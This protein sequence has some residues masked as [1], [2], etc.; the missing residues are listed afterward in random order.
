VGVDFVLQNL[1][2][3][4]DAER[5]GEAPRALQESYPQAALDLTY[6]CT[7]KDPPLMGGETDT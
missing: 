6:I 1:F 5:R 7:E 4:G 3:L 2:L